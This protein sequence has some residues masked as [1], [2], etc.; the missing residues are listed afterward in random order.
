M[1]ERFVVFDVVREKLEPTALG[2]TVLEAFSDAGAVPAGSMWVNRSS[3]RNRGRAPISFQGP[4][5]LFP[6]Q[7]LGSHQSGASG[8]SS[9][10]MRSGAD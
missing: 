8:R 6:A 2:E 1:D 5:E 10:G 3:P 9:R 4:T 7:V